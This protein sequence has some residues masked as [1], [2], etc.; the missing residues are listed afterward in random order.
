M[1]EFPKSINIDVNPIIK[2]GTAN[3]CIAA[4]EL[5]MNQNPEIDIIGERLSDGYIHL[6]AVKRKDPE[7]P[8]EGK[9]W[10]K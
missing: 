6:K 5:F 8:R 4:L 1:A 7:L 2:P 9:A 10:K 3:L